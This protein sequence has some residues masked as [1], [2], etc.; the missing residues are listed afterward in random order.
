MVKNLLMLLLFCPICLSAQNKLLEGTV[1]EYNNRPTIFINDQPAS[2]QFYSLTH[3]YGARWSWEE[4]PSRNLKNFCMLG[5]RLFQVDLYFEDIWYKDNQKLDID[6][7]QRQVKGV[8]NVC[9]EAAIVIRIHINAPYW[10]N[11]KNRDECTE[12]ADAPVDMRLYGPPNDNENGDVEHPLRASLASLKWRKEASDKLVEFCQRLAVTEEGSSV[13][14]LHIS[15]GVYGEWHYGGFPEHDPDTGPAMISYFKNWLTKKYKTDTALQKAWNNRSISFQSVTVPGKIERDTTTNGV[16]R[17]PKLDQRVMDYYECQQY[18]VAEDII[19]F[20]KLAKESW[21]RPLIIGVFYNYFF[22]TFS[23]Q[24]AGGHLQHEMIL[25]TPYIDYLS[26]PQSY[27]GGARKPGG[28]GQSRG[29]VESAI[30]HKKLWLDE[31]DQNSY[32][33]GPFNAGFTTTREQDIG[34]IR[35]NLAQAITRGGSYWFYD[36]GPYRSSGWWG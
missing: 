25:N 14:G 35:R 20:S 29:L 21:P 3:A 16:F 15:C 6:K 2:P 30:L 10:W 7:A 24:A 8:L 4:V 19:H 34:I 36:F 5:F 11:E 32:K 22:M 27:W 23:R 9:P 18:V 12:Y 28:S 26:A 31:M 1:K 17:N 13:I 33:G